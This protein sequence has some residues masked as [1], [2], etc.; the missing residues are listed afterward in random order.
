M[1]I[2]R[3]DYTT[4]D[5]EGY[6]QGMIEE[7]P[8]KLPEWT[9]RSENDVGIVLLELLAKQLESQSYYND[10]VANEVFL[11]TATQRRSVINHCKLI[12]YELSWHTAS[13]FYQV[14]EV[15]PQLEPVVIPRGFQIGTKGS[16][17]EESVIFETLEDLI[18]PSGATGLE[19]DENG[20]YLYKVEIEQGQTITDEFL[21]NIT[22]N[23]S[24]QR[25]QFAYSPILRE[26]IDIYVDEPTSGKRQWEKVL[27][28]IGSEQLDMHY[29]TEMNEYDEV[30]IQF[31]SGSSGRIPELYSKVFANYKVGGGTIGNVGSNTIV[32]MYESVPGLIATFNPSDPHIFGRDK[33]SMDEAKWRGPASLKRLDRYVTLEDYENGIMLDVAGIAKAKAINVGGNVDLFVL[34][35]NGEVPSSDMKMEILRTVEEKKVMFTKVFVKDPVYLDF[36]I[37]VNIIMYDNYDPEMIRYG[38]EFILRDMFDISNVNFG[39]DVKVAEIHHELFK[40]EGVRNSI[41]LD[42]LSDYETTDVTI[43]RLKGVE[44][45]VN[46]R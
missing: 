11:S 4:K 5:Y 42:P 24:N 43:P 34:P 3:I 27:D 33:E 40:L 38:V 7:I 2:K 26:S 13:R 46:G 39:D 35:I 14:F 25:F 37:K 9:D 36:N 21:G 1:A 16:D 19:K 29:I 45:L 6:R 12:G 31:G 44:V 8:S 18:I 20:E 28:F 32:E 10:R 30:F 23:E 17:I 15:V 41:I 22:T